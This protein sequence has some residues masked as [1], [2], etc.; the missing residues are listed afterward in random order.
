MSWRRRDPVGAAGLLL[1]LALAILPI[2]LSLVYAALYSVGLTGLL[3]RGLTWEHWRAVLGSRELWASLGLSAGV[4]LAVVSAT[5]AAALTL[6]LSLR[7]RVERGPVSYLLHLPLALPGAVAAFLVF[8]MLTGGGLVPR[9]LV[10][11]GLSA[12]VSLVQDR[13]ALGI[14]F[15]HVGLAVPFFTL[16]FADLYRSERIGELAALARSLGADTGQCLRRVEIP[17][18]LRAAAANLAL[19]FIVILGSYEIPLLLGR[20]AP[21]MLSVLTLR[22]YALFDISQKPQAFVVALVYTALVLA[23]IGVLF[24]GERRPHG[25]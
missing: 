3:G 1:F 6:A 17:L 24:R 10:R 18:L 2:G 13:W 23:L 14:V 5:T 25:S 15:A 9:A 20:Q 21:Q 22:K 7:E 12:P 4:A 11:L 19:L 8:Q 16:L